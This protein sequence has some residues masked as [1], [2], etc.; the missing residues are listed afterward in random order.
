MWGDEGK[1]KLVTYLA[2]KNDLTLRCSGGSNA[3]HRIIYK[4][5]VLVLSSIPVGIFQG[6]KAIITGNVVLNLKSLWEDILLCEKYLGP[7]K[8]KLYISENC[9]IIFPHHISLNQSLHNHMGTSGEGIATANADRLLRRGI[10]LKRYYAGE[11]V[12][13]PADLKEI[14]SHIKQ[15][16]TN[17]TKMIFSENQKNS[18]LTILIEG[19][20]GF[21]LDNLHGTY[22]YVTSSAISTAGLL[23]GAGLPVSTLKHNIG[24]AGAYLV[25]A[26][27][28]PLITRVAV[29]EEKILQH[30]GNEYIP[31]FDRW[32][33][34]FWLDLVALQYSHNI[35]HYSELC[36]NKLDVLSHVETI[37][38]CVGYQLNGSVVQQVYDW[39]DFHTYHF[40]PVYQTLPGWSQEITGCQKYEELP[41]Q[42]KNF[43]RF[44]EDKL[45]VPVNL[46][47]TGPKSDDIIDRNHKLR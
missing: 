26:I 40:S 14:L 28:E 30:Y 2:S 38:I 20:Q 35:N 12:E 22:P 5:N 13:L 27:H 41:E 31:L 29:K 44:I 15:Y 25:R 23:H 19:S 45:L 36:I 32:R 43:I 10:T 46:I 11:P 37:N 21:M 8:G 39:N 33:D 18:N 42:A 4:K 47:G 34:C 3:R 9:H 7:L 17:T 24:V 1:G 6:S 16:M